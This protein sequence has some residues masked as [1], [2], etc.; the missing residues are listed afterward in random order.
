MT[1]VFLGTLFHFAVIA[2]NSING[3]SIVTHPATVE[4][5]SHVI[6]RLVNVLMVCVRLVLMVTLAVMNV[7]LGDMV[8]IVETSVV[9]ASME[10]HVN[11]PM[12]LV[13]VV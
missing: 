5:R 12:E 8:L 11:Q 10:N 2:V 1:N 6:G 4:M 9:A 3:E 7:S 13:L